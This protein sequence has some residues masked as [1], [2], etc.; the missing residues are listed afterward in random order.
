MFLGIP[1]DS[2]SSTILYACLSHMKILFRSIG[3]KPAAKTISIGMVD[4]IPTILSKGR[5]SI[6]GSA[7]SK[8]SLNFR[9]MINITN[10]I[11]YIF[12]PITSGNSLSP[13]TISVRDFPCSLIFFPLF[14][15]K[16]EKTLAGSQFSFFLKIGYFG[17]WSEQSHG[18]TSIGNYNFFALLYPLQIP[19]KVIPYFP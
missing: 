16:P 18:F 19:S 9:F 13:G 7:G 14:T 12:A 1:A 15:R 17:Y 10:S 4:V 8:L 3:K 5:S 11:F 2:A 6:M